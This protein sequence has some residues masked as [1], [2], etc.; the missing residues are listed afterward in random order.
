MLRQISPVRP[1]TRAL[2]LLDK[3]MLSPTLQAI[4]RIT[5]TRCGTCDIIFNAIH[6][7]PSTVSCN[8]TMF[9]HFNHA[10]LCSRARRGDNLCC[11]AFRKENCKPYIKHSICKL[12]QR[13]DSVSSQ[14]TSEYSLSA[15]THFSNIHDLQSWFLS[16]NLLGFLD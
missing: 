16:K 11:V 7:L 2:W 1:S 3:E 15:T 14:I 5:E 12:K 4:L 9:T 13:G 10:L 6:V 8:Y